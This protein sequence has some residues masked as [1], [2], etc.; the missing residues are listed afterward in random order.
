MR[1]RVFLEKISNGWDSAGRRSSALGRPLCGVG[2]F[3]W[4]GEVPAACVLQLGKAEAQEKMLEAK[5]TAL[6]HK[7]RGG[8]THAV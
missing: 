5:N 6:K 7:V 8:T 2:V 4:L 3:H 1:M